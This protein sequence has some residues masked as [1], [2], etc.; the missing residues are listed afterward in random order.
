MSIRKGDNSA[1]KLARD[2][3]VHIQTVT[4]CAKKVLNLIGD[5]GTSNKNHSKIL[6]DTHQ[7]G[8]TKKTDCQVSVWQLSYGKVYFTMIH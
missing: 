4:Q 3:N 5:K 1:D 2:S 6:L 7:S 8:K